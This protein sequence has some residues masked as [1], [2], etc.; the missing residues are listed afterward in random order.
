MI[1]YINIYIYIYIYISISIYIYILYKYIYTVKPL[2][3]DPA[4][5]KCQKWSFK[6][7]S[8]VM[9]KTKNFQQ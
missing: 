4:Q 2:L 7:L 1:I 8:E 5:G 3:S 6:G 9:K